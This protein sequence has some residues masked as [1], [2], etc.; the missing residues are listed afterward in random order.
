MLDPKLVFTLEEVENLDFGDI[1]VGRWSG[2]KYWVTAV[3]TK[4]SD[5]YLFLENDFWAGWVSCTR[6]VGPPVNF[7]S[8]EKEFRYTLREIEDWERDGHMTIK[9]FKSLVRSRV[10]NN[11]DGFACYA[12]KDK[13]THVIVRPSH[14][15][16]GELDP[17]YTHVIWYN[18]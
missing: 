1:V 10:F 3:K 7:Y 4:G 9:E 13:R 12:T 8:G 16:A 2:N 5:K 18:R 17:D 15:L 11:Q 6:I 14:V